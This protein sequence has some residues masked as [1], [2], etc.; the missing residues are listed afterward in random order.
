MS[1]KNNTP[2]HSEGELKFQMQAMTHMMERMNFLMGN[3]ADQPDTKRNH[4]NNPLEVPIGPIIKARAKKIKE[5]LNGLVLNI[6]SKMNLKGLGSINQV[7]S[8]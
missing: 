6:W 8:F 4:A 3:D 2:T 1:N 7:I 5:A